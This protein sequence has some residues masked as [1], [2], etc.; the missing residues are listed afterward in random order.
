MGLSEKYE[1][2]L[3]VD[4]TFG[5]CGFVC[6][7]I[8]NGAHVVVSSATKWIGGHGTTI[9]GVIVDSGKFNWGAPVRSVLGDPT[10]APKKDADGK[11][12]AKYPLINGPCA[13]YHDMDLWSV[14]GPSGPFG[15]NIVFAVRCRI[16]GLRDIGACQNPFGAFM[17]VQGLETLS[18][19]GRAHCN[20][21]N[22]LAEWLSSHDQVAWVSHPSLKSHAAH[23][24]AKK[25]FRAGCFGAVLCFGVK[26]GHEA[27]VKFL[28]A[29]KLA[30]HLA[31]VGDAK[32]LVIHPASTTHEQ[33]TDEEQLSG[34]VANDMVRVSV[35]IEHIDDI[36]EDFAHALKA[37]RAPSKL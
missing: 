17:L 35:G 32:T 7:P 4:N 9:G 3:F 5:M 11:E 26:G 15:A 8:Q 31:N 23:E 28:D 1:L 21:A 33:L 30:S 20:N 18:L 29:L 6:R 10:S 37:S 2:P 24:D 27:C 14:F 19:L 16:I 12:V 22:A 34:G 25:Y 13:A 36:K